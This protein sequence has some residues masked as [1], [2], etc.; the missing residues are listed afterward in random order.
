[1][2]N[3]QGE[4]LIDIENKNLEEK[5]LGLVK[6]IEEKTVLMDK[7]VEEKTKGTDEIEVKMKTSL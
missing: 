7:N 6:E 2:H 4:L 1:M 5:Y 3:E